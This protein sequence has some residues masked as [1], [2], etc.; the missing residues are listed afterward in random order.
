MFQG[1]LVGIV[2]QFDESIGS[3]CRGSKVDL[4]LLLNS[5][6]SQLAVIVSSPQ[7]VIG[8]IR[9]LPKEITELNIFCKD[10]E[11]APFK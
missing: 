2:F 5:F 3:S 4:L 1:L 9:T 8:F 6:W 7:L 11:K 10:S